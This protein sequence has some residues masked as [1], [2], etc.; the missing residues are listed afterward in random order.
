[1]RS[2]GSAGSVHAKIVL[3]LRNAFAIWTHEVDR[4]SDMHDVLSANCS[5]VIMSHLV[6]SS[7]V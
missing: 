4:L 6:E 2:H 1:M 7:R 3:L 5:R